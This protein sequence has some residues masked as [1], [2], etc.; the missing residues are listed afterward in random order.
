MSEDL[1]DSMR[2]WELLPQKRTPVW[3]SFWEPWFS[4]YMQ[5]IGRN[6]NRRD[7]STLPYRCFILVSCHIVSFLK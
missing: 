7:M 2:L 5:P 6:G 1:L 4:E 3:I